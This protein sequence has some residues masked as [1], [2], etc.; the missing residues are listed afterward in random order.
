MKKHIIHILGILL[1]V[2]IFASCGTAK[3]SVANEQYARGEYFD[4]A[5]TYRKVYNKLRK[6][7]DRP[8]RGQVAFMMGDCYRRLNMTARASAAFTNAVRYKYADV[9]STTYLYLAQCRHAEGKYKDAIANYEL[10]LEKNPD[11]RVAHNGMIGCV[12]AVEWKENPT[13]YT[14]KK[15]NLFNTRRSDCSPMLQGEQFEQL[16]ITS[17]SD[18]ATGEKKSSITG[19][20]NYDIFLAEK[21]E[22]GVWQKPELIEGELNTEA[23]EGMVSF[24]PDGSTM[25]LSKARQDPNQNAS[26]EIF[27]STRSG[28]QWSAP[29]KLN[30]V[31]DTISS[32]AHPAV[33]P[34]GLF[35]YFTSDMPGGQGGTD[36][37]RVGLGTNTEGTLENLGDKINTPGDEMFPYMRGDSILYFYLLILLRK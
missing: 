29:V 8:L 12:K 19:V 7:T 14:V 23:D 26:A 31:A 30:I 10:F 1:G 24:N 27:T 4:A 6:K 28:A 15:A 16:Y 3:L 5:Q 35:L 25:Y 2:A 17:S 32:F 33:S 11:S 20:K 21:D 22:N 9:D 13:R 36:I 34:D 37:W 18:K